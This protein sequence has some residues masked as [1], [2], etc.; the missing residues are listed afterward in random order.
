VI[1]HGHPSLGDGQLGDLVQ[2]VGA[3]KKHLLPALELPLPQQELIG[4]RDAP[5]LQPPHRPEER[6]L[7]PH[8]SHALLACKPAQP[9]VA[10]HP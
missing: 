3:G 6:I 5:M 10:K 1:F 8:R 9:I 4:L 7:L 2:R